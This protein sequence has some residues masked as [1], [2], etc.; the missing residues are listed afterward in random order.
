MLTSSEGSLTTATAGETDCDDDEEDDF[1]GCWILPVPIMSCPRILTPHT[2]QQLSVHFPLSCQGHMLERCFCIGEH[3]DSILSMLYQCRMF[4]YTLMV[5]QTTDGD[6]LGGFATANWN[7][8]RHNVYYG[9]GQSFLFSSCPVVSMEASELGV[10]ENPTLSVFPWSGENDYCQICDPDQ[11]R[12]AMGGAGDF[13]LIVRDN[14]SFG[15][16]GCSRTYRNPPLVPAGRF[17]IAA[18]EVY[19]IVPFSL[20]PQRFASAT[21]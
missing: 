5:I 10:C 1:D 12:I 20:S 14:F 6:V 8:K 15:E 19:G 21:P 18:F 4:R 7:D 11:N 9:D 13:G 17:E 2:L 16:T 3:G